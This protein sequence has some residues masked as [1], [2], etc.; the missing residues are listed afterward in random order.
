MITGR[1]LDVWSKSSGKL[2]ANEA[3]IVGIADTDPAQPFRKNV[4]WLRVDGPESVEGNYTRQSL[5]SCHPSLYRDQFEADGTTPIP[6][7]VCA[8]R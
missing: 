8:Y 3:R 2:S 6:G 7:D 5:A 1:V 4:R